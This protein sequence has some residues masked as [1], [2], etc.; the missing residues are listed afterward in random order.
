MNESLEERLARVE[1][2]LSHL[3]RQNEELNSVVIEQGK[4]LAKL[5]ASV[6]RLSETIETTELDRLHADTRKPP[7]SA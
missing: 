6:R 2:S 1:R 5:Q 3:E 4:T 7:H